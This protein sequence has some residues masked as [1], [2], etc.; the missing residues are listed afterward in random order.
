MNKKYYES[1]YPNG[2]IKERCPLSRSGSRQGWLIKYDENG[3]EIEKL[4]YDNGIL[5]GNPFENK[6]MIEISDKIGISFEENPFKNEEADTEEIFEK[7]NLSSLLYGREY[8]G[9]ER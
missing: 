9:K 2:K 1:F 8:Y 5:I 4:L 7:K 3:K 6:N